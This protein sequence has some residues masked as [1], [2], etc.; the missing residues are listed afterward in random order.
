M[1]MQTR[2]GLHSS[3]DLPRMKPKNILLVGEYSGFHNALKAGLESHGHRVTLIAA[4][5]GFKKY[6]IDIDVR[7]TRYQSSLPRK[8]KNLVYEVTGRDLAGRDSLHQ[9]KSNLEPRYDVI[10]FVNSAPFQFGAREEFAAVD[11]ICSLSDNLYLH[12]GG[13]DVPYVEFGFNHPD[14]RTL[15]QPYLRNKKL[16]PQFRHALKYRKPEYQ[17]FFQGF[18]SQLSGIIPTDA[19]YLEPYQDDS[20]TLPL[21]PAPMVLPSPRPQPL[22]FTGRI[23]IFLGINTTNQETKGVPLFLKVLDNLKSSYGDA[24]E[25]KITKDLPYQQYLRA[26]EGS[27]ILLDQCYSEDQGYNGREAMVRGLVAVSG[28]GKQFQD[29]YNLDREVLIPASSDVA[30]M[31]RRIS[32]LLEDR[33]ALAALAQRGQDHVY[34]HHDHSAVAK[35]YLEAWSRG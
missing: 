17:Q 32:D 31:T 20:L 23:K 12:A 2:R 29:H 19:D 16:K 15:L 25:V 1:K 28:A 14:K 27:H 5:D 26:Y 34:A 6:P 24:I 18:R 13:M 21:I 33:A 4:G 22:D 3:F 35:R 30:D 9:I 8:F 10:Q 11:F 7:S